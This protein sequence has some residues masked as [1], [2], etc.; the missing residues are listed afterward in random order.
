MLGKEYT[1]GKSNNPLHSDTGLGLSTQQQQS[2]L[3]RHK[4]LMHLEGLDDLNLE[5][6]RL[7]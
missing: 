3:Q 5:I 2:I 7:L 4:L 1:L 6:L